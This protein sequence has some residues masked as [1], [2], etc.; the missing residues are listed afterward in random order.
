MIKAALV[1]F[2]LFLTGCAA[3]TSKPIEEKPPLRVVKTKTVFVVSSIAKI[4]E[5]SQSISN[6]IASIGR[7]V[8]QY[9]LALDGSLGF[10]IMDELPQQLT[11]YMPRPKVNLIA[12][13]QQVVH[14]TLQPLYSEVYCDPQTSLHVERRCLNGVV[15]ESPD[16]VIA[17]EPVSV[18]MNIPGSFAGTFAVAIIQG[19]SGEEL[20]QGHFFE[21]RIASRM[22]HQKVAS[23]LAKDIV[24]KLKSFGFVE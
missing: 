23:D 11:S 2:V 3:T 19:D 13:S 15:K 17:I 10:A 6:S 9:T 14:K 5:S 18:G 16:I 20:W 22:A 1:V 8:T 4:N 12:Q 24:K 7:N 21:S